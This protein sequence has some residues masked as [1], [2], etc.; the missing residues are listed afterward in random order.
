[1]KY[2]AVLLGYLAVM[3]HIS[4]YYQLADEGI[5]LDPW[6]TAAY[7]FFPV[8]GTCIAVFLVIVVVA[9]GMHY[10]WWKKP[11]LS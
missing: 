5:F 8:I 1:M 9:V 11:D 6:H 10:K 2:I 7:I 3:M 4:H